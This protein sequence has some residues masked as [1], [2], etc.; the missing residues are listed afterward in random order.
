MGVPASTHIG[1]HAG[2]RVRA[3]HIAVVVNARVLAVGVLPYL[4]TTSMTAT[5]HSPVV[6]TSPVDASK[7]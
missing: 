1:A 5:R 4:E 7:R 3:L 6:I 2:P